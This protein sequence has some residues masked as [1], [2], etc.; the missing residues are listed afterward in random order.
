MRGMV[1]P[2]SLAGRKYGGS[3][4]ICTC[5]RSWSL[6]RG[7]GRAVQRQLEIRSRKLQIRG[8]LSSEADF[9]RAAELKAKEIRRLCSQVTVAIS[10]RVLKDWVRP[11]QYSYKRASLICTEREIQRWGDADSGQG[12]SRDLS[13]PARQYGS[14]TPF[15][16]KLMLEC[17]RVLVQTRRGDYSGLYLHVKLSE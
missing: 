13:N 17:N 3:M 7:Q 4:L 2:A 8:F 5:W 1:K 9:L 14:G 10:G 11:K 6:H 16:R 15:R 12:G